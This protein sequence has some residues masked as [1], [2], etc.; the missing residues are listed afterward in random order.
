M[1]GVAVMNRRRRTRRRVTIALVALLAVVIGGGVAAWTL[2]NPP[3]DTIEVAQPSTDQLETTTQARMFFGHQSVGT[4]VLSGVD[5]LYADGGVTAPPILET[6]E[7][8]AD[9]DAFIA[10]AA[11]GVNGDPWSKLD[12]FT[13][14]VDGSLGEQLDVALLKFCYVDVTAS[15]D[16]Q[17]LFEEYSA[18]MDELAQRHPGI[19]FLY[20]TVPLTTDRSWKANLKALIGRDDQAGPADN[21]ARQ[22]YNELVRERYGDS[23]QLFDIA[24]IEATIAQRP[25]V[26][27]DGGT[28]YFVLNRALASDAGHLNALGAEAAAA[29]LVRVVSANLGR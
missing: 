15:T 24:A 17:A 21:I 11:V 23:G 22:R 19:R 6:V 7:P 26:R 5:P 12:A 1:R 25:A 16:V 2:E 27:T 3:M 28:E 10:H 9:A 8:V 4:N 20:A 29:E 14:I 18:A 13:G